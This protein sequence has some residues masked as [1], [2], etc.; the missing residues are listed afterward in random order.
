MTIEEGRIVCFTVEGWKKFKAKI[1]ALKDQPEFDLFSNVLLDH[2]HKCFIRKRDRVTI[3]LG[4]KKLIGIERDNVIAGVLSHFEIWSKESWDEE[5]LKLTADL[6]AK[7][8]D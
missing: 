8:W 4:L 3:P 5:L 7:Q 6:E 2:S 1:L